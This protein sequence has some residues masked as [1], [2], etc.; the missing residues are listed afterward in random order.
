MFDFHEKRKIRSLVYSKYTIGVLGVLI[1]AFSVSVFERFSVE[2]AMYEKRVAREVE[3]EALLERAAL[4]EEKV[5]HLKNERGVE[6]ELRS[7]FDVAKKGEQVVVII[8]D[9]A[10][11]T[12]QTAQAIEAAPPASW[13]FWDFIKRW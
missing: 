11:N 7:R 2:R 12:A 5:S 1:V 8:D 3:L 13:S 10:P 9:D 6:E 4:L